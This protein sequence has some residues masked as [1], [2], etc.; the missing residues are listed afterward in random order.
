MPWEFASVRP[1][2]AGDRAETLILKAISEKILSNPAWAEL[3][4]TYA[5]RSYD[6]LQRELPSHRR[7]IEDALGDVD[8]RIAMLIANSEKQI[9]PEL[10]SRMAELRA[11]RDSLRAELKTLLADEGRPSG[12]PTREW[13]EERLADLRSLLNG[14]GPAA[15][16]A[17]RALVG[18]KIVVTEIRRAGK[19]RH[20]LRGAWSYGCGLW[21]KPSVPSSM[22]MAKAIRRR[23]KSSRSI[24]VG[25]NAMK[26][27][28]TKPSAFGTK[29]LP[30]TKSAKSFIAVERW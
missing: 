13:I 21:L 12:P 1:P 26:K 8:G 25:R 16:H 18:G 5:C 2:C 30:T 22:M 28:P 29:V 15:A 27:L 24:F 3:L 20:Y 7:V 11:K 14:H 10:E 17:L 9:V 19:Q 23:P 4:L 6:K